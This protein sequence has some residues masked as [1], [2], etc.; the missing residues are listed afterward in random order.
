MTEVSKSS[1]DGGGTAGGTAG[2]SVLLSR[3][4]NREQSGGE[5]PYQQLDTV[6]NASDTAGWQFDVERCLFQADERFWRLVGTLPPATPVCQSEW[7]SLVHPDDLAQLRTELHGHIEG[8]SALF[9]AEHRIRARGGMWVWVGVRGRVIERDEG[10]RAIRVV[11]TYQD[12]SAR[13]HTEA[14]RDEL[15]A[16]LSAA[17]KMESLGVLA[18]TIAHD[19]NNLLSGIIGNV[20]LALLELPPDHSVRPDL[21]TSL[22]TAE[23]AARLCDQL[24]AYSGR[25]RFSLRPVDLS[26]LVREMN[27]VIRS[28]V[29]V[30]I[31]VHFTLPSSIALANCDT[32]QMRRVITNLVS[33]A[34]EAIGDSGGEISISLGQHYCDRAYLRSSYS[35]G[36]LPEGEYVFLEVIDN[37]CGMDEQTRRRVFD[38]FFSTKFTGRGLGLAAVLGITRAHFGMIRVYSELGRGSAFKILLP[39]TPRES[40]TAHPPEAPGEWKGHGGVLLVDDEELVRTVAKRLL[41]RIGFKVYAADS[42]RTGV[43]M[44][45]RNLND[46]RAV[47]LDVT[48]PDMK[49]EEVLRQLRMVKPGVPV[50]LMSGYDEQQ[51]TAGFEPGELAG[52]LQKPIDLKRLRDLMRVTTSTPES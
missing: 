44:L 43:E 27:D 20:E 23:R 32:E 24:L 36:E 48:M 18:G 46:V 29:P 25:G 19:F 1:V 40:A 38:P 17:E 2:A 28:S 21:D 22:K 11:G 52:F 37:G 51:A 39:A 45:Q 15:Q 47:V 13:R 10:G 14:E 42:G 9:E 33:N 35:G 34:A 3:A 49:G 31:S 41:E 12:I 26:G 5:L 6:L 8:H 7:L 4:A 30:N 16:Q 50:V